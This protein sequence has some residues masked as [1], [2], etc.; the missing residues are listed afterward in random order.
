MD[1][2]DS[3]QLTGSR[4][5]AY[6]L[7]GFLIGLLIPL[8]VY[9]M[10]SRIHQPII[11]PGATVI[12]L[13]RGCQ[14]TLMDKSLQPVFTVSLD[15]PGVDSIRLWPLP[16]LQPFIEDWY[17]GKPEDLRAKTGIKLDSF[18]VLNDLYVYIKASEGFL[19]ADRRIYGQ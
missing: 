5:R 3:R 10:A 6:L 17:E 19:E 11:L 4:K 15:C 8:L 7:T 18:K 2:P 13:V 1:S 9:L 16:V 12:K 14:A